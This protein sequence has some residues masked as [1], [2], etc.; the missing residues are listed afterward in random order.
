MSTV[1]RLTNRSING[2]VV[3]KRVTY[4]I[5][6]GFLYNNVIGFNMLISGWRQPTET[7]MNTLVAYINNAGNEGGV[8]KSTRTAPDDAPRWNSPNTGATDL[9]NFGAVPTGIRNAD[10]VFSGLG[11]VCYFWRTSS[12]AFVLQ[13]G[14]ATIT[15]GSYDS[16]HG[17]VPRPMRDAT[18][19][20]QSDIAEG[21][22]GLLYYIGNDGYIY[23]CVRIG[24]QIWVAENLIETIDNSGNEIPIVS[25]ATQ[26]AALT[27]GARCAYNNNLGNVYKI[28]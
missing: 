20:E 11:T 21:T 17:F 3:A 28:I 19:S 9:Y 23:D 10:G 26:W 24:T 1:I 12:S 18:L 14:A 2:R 16:R 4:S 15:T 25:D 8:L 5:K 7:D 6:Y 27:T 13:S 22:K